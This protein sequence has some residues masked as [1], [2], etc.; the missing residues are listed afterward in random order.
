[1]AADQCKMFTPKT[2][3]YS[4]VE[5]APRLLLTFL[6]VK[7]IVHKISVLLFFFFLFLHGKLE[8][9]R[10]HVNILHTKQLLYYLRCSFSG[11]ELHASYDW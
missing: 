10:V 11:L 4:I 6:K 3:H 2:L 8:N 7:K 1:M 9:Y 5:N